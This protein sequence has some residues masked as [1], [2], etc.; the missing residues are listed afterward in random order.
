MTANNGLVVNHGVM[1]ENIGATVAI[2]DILLQSLGGR[3]RFFSEWNATDLGAASFATLRA[4]GAFVVSGCIDADGTV[5]PVSLES[6][7][8]GTVVFDSPW[9]GASRSPS[10]PAPRSPRRRSS[11]ACTRTEFPPWCC[12]R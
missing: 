10:R 7:V 6:E 12:R 11:L 5:A 3:L 9:A 8:G 4:Y 1:L 2:N